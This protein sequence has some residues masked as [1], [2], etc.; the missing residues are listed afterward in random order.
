MRPEV[1]QILRFSAG[2]LMTGIAPALGDSFA[3]GSVSLIGFMLL[4]SAQEF[5]RAA[6]I[7]ATENAQ[8]RALFAALSQETR[9][10]SL[11]A[12]LAA[13]A[14]TRDDSLV[15]SSL[16]AANYELRRLLIALQ[17]ELEDSGNRAANRRVWD[18][19]KAMADRRVVSPPGA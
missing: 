15:I 4:L 9:D 18:V 16:N 5:D 10:P 17:S 11:R 6:D 19:L 1:D 14:K 7:R 3:Q 12:K 13:A 2:Q 8:I